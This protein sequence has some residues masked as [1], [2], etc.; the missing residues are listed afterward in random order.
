MRVAATRFA[1]SEEGTGLVEFALVVPTLILV[2]VVALDFARVSNAQVTITNASREAARYWVVH[3]TA[4]AGDI[5][6]FLASRV[7][8]LNAAMIVVDITY[9]PSTDVRW[10]TAA[11]SPASV[12]IQV[13]YPWT[14]LTLAGTF[15][16]LVIDPA[17]NLKTL[18]LVATTQM[19][20]MQWP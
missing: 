14:E 6:L 5:E 18:K 8:P 20:T 4:N 12:V 17:T 7:Q 19:E 2:L 1:L 16:P 15:L 11:P 3:P 13:T 9:L 10:N